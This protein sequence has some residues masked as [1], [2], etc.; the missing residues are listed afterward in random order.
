[1]AEFTPI[2]L[3]Y[4]GSDPTGF[5]E[6]QSNESLDLQT[7]IGIR[8]INFENSTTIPVVDGEYVT[9]K[10]W[11]LLSF[12]KRDGEDHTYQDA[13]YNTNLNLESSYGSIVFNEENTS[14][15]PDNGGANQLKLS[16]NIYHDAVTTLTSNV[17]ALVLR[18]PL[19]EDTNVLKFIISFESTAGNIVYG[20]EL[21]VARSSTV[22]DFQ[23]YGIVK[24]GSVDISLSFA[25]VLPNVLEIT[26][27][28]SVNGTVKIRRVH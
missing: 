21:M 3:V 6:Y 17:G 10:E 25:Y 20:S 11:Q 22:I 27:E 1:M 14:F 7:D 15:P 4:S 13:D 2:R 23:E 16:Y 24:I 28:S 5:S 8:Q 9:D 19:I 18:T 12:T 26:V